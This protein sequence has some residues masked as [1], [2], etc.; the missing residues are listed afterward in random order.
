MPC[1][2]RIIAALARQA[3][4]RPLTDADTEMLFGYYKEGRQEGSFES[5]IRMAVQA[6][7][8]NPKFLFRFE[9]PAGPAAPTAATYRIT[10]LELAS[11]LS[12]F[13]WSSA[14]D[15]PLLALAAAGQAARAGGARARG[16]AHAG[17][18]GAPRR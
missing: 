6:I 14:P 4:R 13:L 1:A 18:S 9:R 15:E 11:R 8:A 17:R 5:G 2:Q 12:Y 16:A 7:L 10:D 3:Y